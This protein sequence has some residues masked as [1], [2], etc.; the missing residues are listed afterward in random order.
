MLRVESPLTDGQEAIVSA[1][2]DCGFAVHKELGP[3]FKEKIY[4]RAFALE[5][6]SRGI[7]FE[8]EKQIEV[9]YRHWRIP[10][11]KIDL[12]VE[13]LVLV[14]LKVVPRLRDIHRD[15]V[16]S[17]LKTL[18]LRVGLLMNFNVSVFKA[19]FRRVVR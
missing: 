15:Q 14:E 12:I 9:R 6:D 13:K 18:E 2:M 4:Q 5:L 7:R 17:Y 3:G 10:G 11:Q 1:V 19:G 16:L 8:A